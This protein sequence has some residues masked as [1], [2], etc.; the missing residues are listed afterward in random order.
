MDASRENLCHYQDEVESFVEIIVTRDETYSYVY[1]FTPELKEPPW[2]GNL[3][4]HPLRRNSEL[5][6]LQK[7]NSNLILGL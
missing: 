2:L 6:H 4:I 7:K 3:L 1:D 5:S